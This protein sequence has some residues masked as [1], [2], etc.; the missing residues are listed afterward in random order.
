MN[1]FTL[2]LMALGFAVAGCRDATTTPE[3]NAAAMT[4]TA[5]GVQVAHEFAMPLAARVRAAMSDC[6]NS[7][8]PFITL[9]G[10]LTLGGL[11]SRMTF[12]NNQKGTHTFRAD[13]AV[14]LVA[15]PAGESITIPKQ[16]PLGGV[17][18]NPFIWIQLDYGNG[19]ALTGETFLGRCV[20]GATKSVDAD[21]SRL[22]SA[23]AQIAVEECSNSPGPRISF[24]GDLTVRSGL[25]VSLIFR[26]NDNPVG[27]PHEA[28]DEQVVRA[29]LLPPGLAVTFPKQPVLGGVG[30]NPWIFFAFTD[31]QT[32]PRL[33]HDNVLLGRCEQLSKA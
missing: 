18:G 6:D 14:D 13:T 20:Q 29:R 27:G 28:T 32:P 11:G 26:N 5:T 17:G 7:P 12:Q 4:P 1:R 30:G 24:G 10:E 22:A 9:S 2:A 33:L 21:F 23:I 15:V 16:P 31:G 19:Q 8:G 3:V 25:G